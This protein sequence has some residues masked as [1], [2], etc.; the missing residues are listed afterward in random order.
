MYNLNYATNQTTHP[1]LYQLNGHYQL[2]LPFLVVVMTVQGIPTGGK[3][4]NG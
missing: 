4:C 2:V 3:D 1:K